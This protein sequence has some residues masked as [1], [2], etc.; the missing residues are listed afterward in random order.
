MKLPELSITRA[1]QLDVVGGALILCFLLLG[2]W[3]FEKPTWLRV[4]ALCVAVVVIIGTL[5]V[6]FLPREKMDERAVK[7]E[8]QANSIICNLLYVLAGVHRVCRGL[9][10]CIV[11]PGPGLCAALAGTQLT[12]PG[13]GTLWRLTMLKTKI[14]ELRMERH[15]EQSELARLVDVRRETIGRLER[16]QYNP[17]LKLAMDIAKVFHTTVEDIFV[18][19]EEPEKKGRA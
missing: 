11:R 1:K 12:V 4:A 5:L 7:N 13:A 15:M 10:D 3:P 6:A 16:G 17:S 18:F 9:R 19:T 8:R 2:K 14:R